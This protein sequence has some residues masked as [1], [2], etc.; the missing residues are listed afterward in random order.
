MLTGA[1]PAFC[2]GA[3]L[4]EFAALSSA[5]AGPG[6]APRRYYGE[7]ARRLFAAHQAGGHRDQRRGD[8]RRRRPRARRRHCHH[9]DDRKA[10]LPGS[11]TR[12]RRFGGDGEFGA[13]GRPQGSLR[14][15]R[16][17][18]ADRCV[19]R[20][21]TRPGQSRRCAADADARGLAIR[22]RH[23]GRGAASHGGDQ[24]AVLPRRR[25]AVRGGARSRPRDEPTHARA[26]ARTSHEPHHRALRRRWRRRH[27]DARSPRG[28]QCAEPRHVRRHCRGHGGGARRCRGAAGA[29]PRQRPGVLRRR[30]PQG[31]QGHGAGRSSRPP[32]R[33]L[34][35]LWGDRKPADAGDRG[36]AGAGG[37]LGLRHRRMLAIL[38]SPPRR[39]PSPRPRRYGGRSA[40]PSGCR[41]SSAS[42]SPRT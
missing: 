25:A 8:G 12:H 13:S 15:R 26:S 23:G 34:R 17:R 4:S 2:A 19:A 6:R 20:R 38:S 30:R 18:R 36:G 39:R 42:S 37:R 10:R 40:P 24:I 31:A 14:A 3:D 29:D 28:P 11:Q 5:N 32:A 21:G 35:R 7:T 41:A 27:L 16:H 22:P 33:R 9:V 1:G